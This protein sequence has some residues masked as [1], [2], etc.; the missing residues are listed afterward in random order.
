MLLLAALTLL[1][2]QAGPQGTPGPARPGS[3]PPDV[4]A[5][6]QESDRDREPPVALVN[7]LELIVNDDCLTRR[8]VEIELMRA[9]MREA[10][11]PKT[12][13]AR[14]EL[15]NEIVGRSVDD[16]LRTQGGKDMGFDNA[17]VQRIV[18]D[19][20]DRR[21]EAAGSIGTLGDEL[22][23]YE[24]DSGAYHQ[25][26]ESYV[27]SSLWVRSVQGRD[28]GPG[29]RN[30]V[31]RYVRPGRLLFE[32]ELNKGRLAREAT[33]RLQEIAVDAA[34]IGDTREARELADRLH[35]L[36]LAG[37][38]F[39]EVG[40]NSGLVAKETRG[41]LEPIEERALM[42]VPGLDSFLPGARPGDVSPVLPVRTRDGVLRGFRIVKLLE[43][44]RPEAPP[45]QDQ[46][47]QKELTERIQEIRDQVRERGALDE[48]ME[49]AYVWPPQYFQRRPDAGAGGEARPAP[50]GSEPG[51]APEPE[52]APTRDPAAPPPLVQPG[53]GGR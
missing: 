30:Y 18:S 20:I 3:T 19:F 10:E 38:D 9:Y 23:K 28:A 6:G 45:F 50:S 43:R 36:I 17:Q 32:Y 40:V 41:V 42:N 31:D 53:A 26:T 24:M 46:G 37:E 48:L 4:Q 2:P 16:L 1:A 12:E 52:R 49:A 13:E 29:G 33:V 27:Y 7:R 11:R 34:L 22:S 44:D 47:F 39:G 21:E 35:R 51:E 5:P 25:D 15:A 14:A 8:D